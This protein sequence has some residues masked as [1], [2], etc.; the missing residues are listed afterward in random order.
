MDEE[1][2]SLARTSV[3][4]LWIHSEVMRAE[5]QPEKAAPK[6]IKEIRRTTNVPWSEFSATLKTER[7]R[8]SADNGNVSAGAFEGNVIAR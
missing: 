2:R 7:I 6:K 4:A 3:R 5:A 8:A 1:D